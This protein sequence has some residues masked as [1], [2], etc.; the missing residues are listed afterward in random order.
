M[1]KLVGIIGVLLALTACGT[2]QPAGSGPSLVTA[3]L[4]KATPTSVAGDPMAAREFAITVRITNTT[5]GP[6]WILGS[7]FAYRTEPPGSTLASRPSTI[8]SPTGNS[9]HC[10]TGPVGPGRSQT[11]TAIFYLGDYYPVTDLVPGVIRWSD[12]SGYSAVGTHGSLV[13]EDWKY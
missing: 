2:S 13:I 12:R 10:S 1:R 9:S 11:C 3:T 7:D 6:M 4:V 8:G 5:S